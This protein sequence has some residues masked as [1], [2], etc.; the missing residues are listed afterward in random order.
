MRVKCKIIKCKNDVVLFLADLGLRKIAKIL[1]NI[2]NLLRESQLLMVAY[3]IVDD[4]ND[5]HWTL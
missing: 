3:Q 4:K 5:S 1:S 2:M